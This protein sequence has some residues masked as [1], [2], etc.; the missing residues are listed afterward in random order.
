MSTGHVK[1]IVSRNTISFWLRSIISMAHV[2]ASY[3]DC[4]A[5]RVRPHKVRK[6]AT[7]LH[8]KRNCAVH[9]VLK[10]GRWSSQL[11]FS[12]FCLRD[13]THRHL[14]TFAIGPVLVAQ[15]VV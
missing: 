9:Q 11:T 7:F 8:F 14:N 15:R 5:L 6:V 3:E 1:K 13:A 4:R 10:A 12:A 2:S